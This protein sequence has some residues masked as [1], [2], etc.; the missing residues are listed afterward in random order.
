MKTKYI[1]VPVSERL[2][3]C[4]KVHVCI[5]LDC[6]GDEIIEKSR[7]YMASENNRFFS[8]TQP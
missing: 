7:Y 8:N 3:T 1:K 2:P 4:D 6:N 5:W